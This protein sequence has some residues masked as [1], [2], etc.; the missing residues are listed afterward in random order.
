MLASGEVRGRELLIAHMSGPGCR[1]GEARL[2]DLDLQTQA[3]HDVLSSTH[4]LVSQLLVPR[5]GGGRVCLREWQV[6]TDRV[7]REVTRAGMADAVD[8][9]RAIIG[10]GED[11]RS[12]RATV[13]AKVTT[14][15]TPD[16]CTCSAPIQIPKAATN[17]RTMT[18]GASVAGRVAAL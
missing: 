6:L 1:L 4:L 10:R 16:R 12:M 9:L 11:G 14:V 13:M 5:V 3:F 8:T 15:S 7:R 17:C 2:S 18:L